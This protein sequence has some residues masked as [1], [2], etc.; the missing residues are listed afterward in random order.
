MKMKKLKRYKVEI[1]V[2]R[3]SVLVIDRSRDAKGTEVIDEIADRVKEALGLEEEYC[4]P[5]G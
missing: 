4:S 1:V 3:N 2:Q 5:C